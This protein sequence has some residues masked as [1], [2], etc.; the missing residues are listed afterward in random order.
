MKIFVLLKKKYISILFL[1]FTVLLVVFANSNLSSAKKGLQL[2]ANNVVPSLFP[3]FVAVELLNNTNLVY[4]L[5]KYL[6]T[7]M[8]PIFN[9]PGIATFPLIMGIISGFPVGAKIVSN[10]Y[11][12][13][14][15]TK[16]EADRMLILSNNSGPLFVIGTAGYAFY[17]SSTIGVLLLVTHIL[18]SLSVGVL[19]GLFSRIHKLSKVSAFNNSSSSNYAIQQHKDIDISELGGVLGSS[20]TSAIKSILVIGGFV[21]IFSVIISMLNRTHLLSIIANFISTIIPV[22]DN[23]ISSFFTGIIEFT[24]GLSAIAS[25]PLKDMSL[26]LALSAFVLGFGGISVTLQVLSIISKYKLSIKKYVLGRVLVGIV[27]SVYTF[28]LFSMPMFNLNV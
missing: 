1:L 20:I 26:K 21:V 25:V 11:S 2:W 6:D 23:L 10:L 4:Y 15:C 24:N 9:L 3:F 16:E 5:S 8:R 22:N 28:I 7:Y 19:I 13:G 17:G 12:S 27:A 18:A 14:A